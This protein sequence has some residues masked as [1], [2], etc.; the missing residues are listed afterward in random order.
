MPQPGYYDTRMA[1]DKTFG[2]EVTNAVN[3]DLDLDRKDIFAGTADP[4]NWVELDKQKLKNR[5]VNHEI[6]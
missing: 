2:H 4:N 5:W 6:P 3:M 1:Y